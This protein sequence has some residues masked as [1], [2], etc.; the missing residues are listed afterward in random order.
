MRFIRLK[1]VCEITSLSKSTIWTMIQN[2]TFPPSIRV[3]DRAVRWDL[4][5][6]EAWMEEK[7]K[8]STK[9]NTG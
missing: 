7:I 5:S 8:A 9:Q 4:A 1:E 2:E 3:G 6:V